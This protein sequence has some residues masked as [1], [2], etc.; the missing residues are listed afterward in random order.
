MLYHK[1][2]QISVPQQE[3]SIELTK[4]ISFVQH[5]FAEEHLFLEVAAL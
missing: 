2:E 5:R 3:L 4:Q 1:A